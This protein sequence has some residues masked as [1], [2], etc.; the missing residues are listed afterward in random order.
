MSSF[1]IKTKT[2]TD[3]NTAID[4]YKK[5][6]QER[7]KKSEELLESI[8]N[9]EVFQEFFPEEEIKKE[10]EE[11]KKELE[12]IPTIQELHQLNVDVCNKKYGE[13]VKYLPKIPAGYQYNLMQIHISIRCYI[14]QINE[15]I[16]PE[17]EQK[18][19]EFLEKLKDFV[20]EKYIEQQINRVKSIDE[21]A[22][23]WGS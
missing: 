18:A 2:L 13:N 19:I 20:A 15:G 22:F 6:I 14:Y 1:I 4:I 5:K 12:N 23:Y 3:I 16:F 7:L 11:L 21:N 8:Q 9:D 17:R 10:V